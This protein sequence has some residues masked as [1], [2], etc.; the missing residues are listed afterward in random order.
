G[1]ARVALQTDAPEEALQWIKKARRLDSKDPYLHLIHGIVLGQLGRDSEAEPHLAIGQG[2]NPTLHDPW[3]REVTLGRNRDSDLFERGLAMESEGNWAGAIE[4][5]QELMRARPDEVFVPLRLARALVQSNRAAEALDLSEKT[6]E[7][8]PTNLDFLVFYAALL[9]KRGDRERSWEACERALKSAPDRPEAYS[10]QSTLFAREGKNQEA[11][12]AAQK[13]VDM[14]PA[15]CASYEVLAQ[16]YAA[17]QQPWE[18]VRVLENAL[19][20]EGLTPSQ[21]LYEMLIQGLKAIQ[22]QDKLPP[23]LERARAEYGDEAFPQ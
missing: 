20:Q 22:R 3:S 5:Y 4:A 15:N 9:A 6:L 8:Y 19:E 1:L 7:K 18:A 16:R 10:L 17:M 23:I 12:A 14:A 21:R 11:L 2:S 13:A